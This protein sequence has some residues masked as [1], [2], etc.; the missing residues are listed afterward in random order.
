[1]RRGYRRLLAAVLTF[2]VAAGLGAVATPSPAAAH[3]TGPCERYELEQNLGEVHRRV[4]LQKVVNNNP[5]TT[6]VTFTS[7][8]SETVSTTW[9]SSTTISGGVSIEVISTSVSTT[10]GISVTNSVTTTI[11]A[12]VGP[13]QLPPGKT[14]FGAWGVFGQKTRGTYVKLICSAAGHT[15]PPQTAFGT[16]F[17]P[18]A[19]GWKVWQQ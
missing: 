17:S 9:S 14:Q 5:T 1:M 4:E 13:M 12:Q 16:A 11:G 19:K 10:L 3:H 15:R 7:S 2:G 8:V 18:I 6:P